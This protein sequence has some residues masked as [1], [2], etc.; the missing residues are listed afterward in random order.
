MIPITE[1]LS[2]RRHKNCFE[3]IYD[4]R[5]FYFKKHNTYSKHY[6]F[7]KCYNY[8]LE[9]YRKRNLNLKIVILI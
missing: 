4:N 1:F 6:A 3:F 2:I 8:Y 9:N 5:K 7:N